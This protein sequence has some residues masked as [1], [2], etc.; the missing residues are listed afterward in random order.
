MLLEASRDEKR[1]EGNWKGIP[2]QGVSYRPMSVK[3]RSGSERNVNP[4]C[5]TIAGL[6][7]AGIRLVRVT[8]YTRYI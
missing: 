7:L 2:Y 5:A 6:R 3:C 8:K 4:Q 1:K